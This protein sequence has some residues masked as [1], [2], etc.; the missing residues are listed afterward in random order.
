MM[1]KRTTTLI[2]SSKNDGLLFSNGVKRQGRS[3][4]VLTGFI[5]PEESSLQ[6]T[7]QPTGTVHLPGLTLTWLNKLRQDG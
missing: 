7:L 3:D 5:S 6:M 2:W 4:G 1:G